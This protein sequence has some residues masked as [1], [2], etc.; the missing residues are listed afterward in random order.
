MLEHLFGQCG[1]QRPSVRPLLGF[2]EGRFDADV[3]PGER[4]LLERHQSATARDCLRESLG[5]NRLG[6][7]V[8]QARGGLRGLLFVQGVGPGAQ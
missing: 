5:E 3:V 7:D 1:P 2:V 4:A 8:P 6:Q